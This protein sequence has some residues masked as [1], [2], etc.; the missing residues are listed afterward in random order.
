MYITKNII[1]VSKIAGLD[2]EIVKCWLSS[3]EDI[4]ITNEE[5]MTK[6]KKYDELQVQYEALTREFYQLKKVYLMTTN[7]SVNDN[8]RAAPY[9]KQNVP[10]DLRL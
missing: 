9:D 3:L 4:L 1:S 5:A 6:A 10:V 8:S 7:G 2:E